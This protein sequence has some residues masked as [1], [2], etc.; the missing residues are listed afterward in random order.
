MDLRP[1]WWRCFHFSTD[2]APDFPIASR[3]FGNGTI[4]VDLFFMISGFIVYYITFSE[5]NGL[6]SS[7]LFLIKRLC[8]IVP[9]YFIATLF[10]AG[11]S[12]DKLHFTL[13]SL[14][15]L[16][17]DITQPAPYFGYPRLFIGWSL[18]YELFLYNYCLFYYI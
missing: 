15:F 3:L 14:L 16:P 8:R 12:W 2:L 18:N 11:D 9:P 10:I 6:N 1:C 17:G 13:H 7:K 5:N 4:G